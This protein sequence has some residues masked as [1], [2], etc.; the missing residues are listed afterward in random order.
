MWLLGTFSRTIR[1]H[2]LLRHGMWMKLCHRGRA[3]SG[4]AIILG[5][6]PL[7]AWYMSGKSPPITSASNSDFPCRMI[8]VTLYFPN[9]LNKRAYTYHKR[10][11][12]RIKIFLASIY[13]PVDHEDQKRSN[14]ELA[15]FYNSIP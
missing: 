5:P 10:G 3:S 15:S 2:L 9:C 6:A 7:W 11:K 8:G 14:K 4:V 12:G 1:G 13:H